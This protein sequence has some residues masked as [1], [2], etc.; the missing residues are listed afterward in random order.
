MDAIHSARSLAKESVKPIESK[1]DKEKEKDEPQKY[2]V[3]RQSE[4]VS[5]GSEAG[6]LVERNTVT[7][8]LLGLRI[9]VAEKRS[10]ALRRLRGIVKI[11]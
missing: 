2:P 6:M 8:S 3:Y 1:K 4:L 7:S 5:C 9:R 11:A 10:R